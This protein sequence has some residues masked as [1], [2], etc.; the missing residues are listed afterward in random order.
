M[1]EKLEKYYGT[2]RSSSLGTGRVLYLPKEWGFSFGEIVKFKAYPMNRPDD[3]V[4]LYRKICRAGT[5]STVVYL[6]RSWGFE[7]DDLIVF[8]VTRTDKGFI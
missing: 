5:D 4:N 3:S 8:S 2:K 7:D 6:D 1:V